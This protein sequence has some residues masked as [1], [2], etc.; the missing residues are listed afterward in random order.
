MEPNR[1]PYHTMP[2]NTIPYVDDNMLI[3]MMMTS[4]MI[5]V[6]IKDVDD[7]GAAQE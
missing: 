2:D 3:M 6:K 5:M 7:D 1:M 4:I